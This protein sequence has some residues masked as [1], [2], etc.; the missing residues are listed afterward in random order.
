MRLKAQNYCITISYRY[1]LNPGGC[2]CKSCFII[3]AANVDKDKAEKIAKILFPDYVDVVVESVEN[4]E[5]TL[6]WEDYETLHM[7][8]N[9]HLLA[10]M[11]GTK[12]T[13]DKISHP[14]D[15]KYKKLLE[16]MTAR[17][18]Q[19]QPPFCC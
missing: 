2:P 7:M 14:L 16:K 13:Y 5:N 12:T 1:G 4:D 3:K 17:K 9:D 18:K 11:K 10:S 19:F 15:M 6:T 8:V